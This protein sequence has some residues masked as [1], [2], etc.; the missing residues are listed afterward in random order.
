MAHTKVL[1]EAVTIKVAGEWMTLKAVMTTTSGG[2]RVA[3]IGSNGKE[4]YSEPLCRSQFKGFRE[5]K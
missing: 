2:R 3:Y 1:S 4:V 5:V